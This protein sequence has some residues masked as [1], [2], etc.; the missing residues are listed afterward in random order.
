MSSISALEK[1]R[2]IT[3]VYD[4]G[5]VKENTVRIGFQRFRSGN[6][7]LQ[8]KPRGQPNTKVD[9]EDLMATVEVDPS[10]TTSELAAG[11]GVSDK[12]VLMYLKQIKK[13]K[14]LKGG[15]VMN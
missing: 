7:D 4:G 6:F 1:S 15:Y 14:S 11:C 2:K 3:D 5:A 9:K 13:V 10:Q 8:N 12:T